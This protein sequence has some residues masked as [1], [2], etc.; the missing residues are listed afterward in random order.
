[1]L[2]MR[3]REWSWGSGRLVAG[4]LTAIVS[5]T[6]VSAR[7]EGP[8]PEAKQAF[9]DGR[10]AFERGEYAVALQLFER[11]AL[12]APAPSLYY[13]I[14]VTQEHLDHFEDAAFA[15]EK[16]LQLCDPPQNDQE[17]KFQGDLR[18]RATADRARGANPAAPHPQPPP[19]PMPQPPPQPP[20]PRYPPYYYVPVP[21][22]A[23]PLS[24]LERLERDRRHRNNGIALLVVGGVFTLAGAGQVAWTVTTPLISDGAARGLSIW[25]ATFPLVVGV[26]L[27]IPGAVATPR[28]QHELNAERRRPPDGAAAA[29]A[30]LEIGAPPSLGIPSQVLAMP[31][32]AM[33]STPVIRF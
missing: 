14:G 28:W 16:Y 13:N 11:A 2:A 5:M 33:F 8:P 6:S 1:M 22:G 21:V 30:A 10:A 3:I 23:M 31:A 7:A 20:G 4:A 12:I 26:T 27:V 19:G 25:A 24:H 15:F 9:V 17:R 32:P 29:R 18:E